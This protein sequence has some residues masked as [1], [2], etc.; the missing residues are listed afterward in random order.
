M[1]GLSSRIFKFLIIAVV[2][3]L[4]IVSVCL[5]AT[6][7]CGNKG[8]SPKTTLST[9]TKDSSEGSGGFSS[10]EFE[11]LYAEECDFGAVAGARSGRSVRNASINT[12]QFKTDKVVDYTVIVAF[13]NLSGGPVTWSQDKIDNIMLSLNDDDPQNDIYSVHEYFEEQF[14]GK[15]NF[16]ASYVV[17]DSASYYSSFANRPTSTSGTFGM[18]S[19]LYAEAVCCADKIVDENGQASEYSGTVVYN[20][21]MLYFPYDSTGWRTCFWPH[22]WYQGNLVVTPY[23]ISGEEGP[24]VGTYA[25]EFIHA[26]GIRDMYTYTDTDEVPVGR[27]D[28]MAQNNDYNPQSLCAYFKSKL[29]VVSESDYGYTD[30]SKIRVV[31]GSGE[32]TLAQNKSQTGTIALKFAERTIQVHG[33]CSYGSCPEHSSSGGGVSYSETGKEMFFV[34]YKVKARSTNE[35]DRWLPDSGLVIYR[36]VDSTHTCLLGNARSEMLGQVKYQMYILRPGNGDVYFAPIKKGQ[37]YGTTDDSISSDRVISYYDGTNSRISVTFK[38]YDSESNAIVEFD[39]ADDIDSHGASGVLYETGQFISNA[40][41][42]VSNLNKDGSYSNSKFTGVRTDENGYFFV[43]GLKSGAKLTFF[44]NGE[45]LNAELTMGDLNLFDQEV[46]NISTKRY[47]ISGV[48]KVDGEVFGGAKILILVPTISGKHDVKLWDGVTD[49]NGYFCVTDLENGS[50][51]VFTNFGNSF[52]GYASRTVQ[53]V[54]GSDIL[55]AEV[56]YTKTYCRVIYY[57]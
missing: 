38:G 37:T 51:L 49:E 48:L 8:E 30:D 53:T 39:F 2:V 52:G 24:F 31:S 50:R 23:N 56:L 46:I 34:E 54:K 40:Q 25:H 5:G 41:V 29:N 55:N 18:E 4:V 1:Q 7:L 42:M 36:V 21:G 15:L 12:S 33:R 13:V 44:K 22:S 11:H 27:W 32:Y 35:A 26:F 16:K 20:C 19:T 10:I 28:L 3:M 6:L 43:K 45:M 47:T 17:Y 9:E 57:N 14:Y